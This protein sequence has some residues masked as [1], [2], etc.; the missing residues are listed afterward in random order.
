M[1]AKGAAFKARSTV[2]SL[3]LH[4][5]AGISATL[6]LSGCEQQAA[7]QRT[8]P[9]SAKLEVSAQTLRPQPAAITAE[10]PGRTSAY[11]VAEVRPRVSGIIRSRNFVEGSEIKAGD[12]LYEIDPSPLQATYATAVAALQHTEGAVPNAEAK[13]ERARSLQTQNIVSR[14]ALGD[15]EVAALQARA[16]VASAKAAVETARINLDH[17]TIRAPI[18]G[19]IDASN[20]TVGALVTADQ[21]TVLTTI[22][23]LDRI[24][25]DLTQSS[26]NLLR[27]RKAIA[28]GRI[29]A[30]G[31]EVAVQLEL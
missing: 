16:D 2:K 4:F 3:P 10:L 29:K 31:N 30:N 14:E 7:A 12:V 25:V 20:V 19:R 24:N 15:A 6:L 5:I 26:M 22:R 8:P 28:E 13:L 17:A 9:P 1:H 27:L 23:E 11:L 21:T 18:G